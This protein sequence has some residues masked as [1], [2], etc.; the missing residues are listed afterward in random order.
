MDGTA[1][2]VLSH[3][4]AKGSG[5][6]REES[7]SR[8]RLLGM[9]S[10]QEKLSKRTILKAACRGR[11]AL[12]WAQDLKHSGTDLVVGEQ[13]FSRSGQFIPLGRSDSLHLDSS[14]S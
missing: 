4:Q 2:P 10:A 11:M 14:A 9:I 12:G 8:V 1:S 3:P 5:L 13:A 7:G 6:K